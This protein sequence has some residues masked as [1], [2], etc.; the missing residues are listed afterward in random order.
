MKRMTIVQ[1]SSSKFEESNVYGRPQGNE[2]GA[3][4]IWRHVMWVTMK[5][6]TEA[7]PA[8]QYLTYLR[9]LR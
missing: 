2:S 9:Y 8:E 1:I 3:V 7:M 5:A 4:V 6:G